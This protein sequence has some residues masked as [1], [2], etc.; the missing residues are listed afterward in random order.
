VLFALRSTPQIKH[1]LE[2]KRDAAGAITIDDAYNS[3]P[4]GFASGLDA[5]DALHAPNGRRILVTPGMVELGAAHDEEHR[6]IGTLAGARVDVLLPVVPQRIEALIAAYK[7]ANPAGLIVPCDN[8]AAAQAWLS[9][10]L[11]PGDIV[12]LENDLPDLYEAKLSL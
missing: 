4:I 2:V 10:N 9:A 1:R 7:A 8:L 12:L 3:N 5:L 6:K 11:R